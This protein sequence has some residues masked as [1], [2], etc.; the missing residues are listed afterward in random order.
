MSSD[1]VHSVSLF[2]KEIVLLKKPL[3]ADPQYAV[4]LSPL[5]S[6]AGAHRVLCSVHPHLSFSSPVT[7][8]RRRWPPVA[9]SKWRTVGVGVVG[10]GARDAAAAMAAR[11]TAPAGS[12]VTAWP[13][14]PVFGGPGGGGGGYVGAGVIVSSSGHVSRLAMAG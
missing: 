5:C 1:S 6:C 8:D 12:I 4:A 11:W 13:R 14:L 2:P 7:P 3:L 10:G 9:A